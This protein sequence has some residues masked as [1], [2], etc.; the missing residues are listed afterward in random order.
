METKIDILVQM[1]ASV[2]GCV[3]IIYGMFALKDGKIK[4]IFAKLGE[5]TLEIYVI[6]YHFANMLNFNNKQYD[7]YTPEGFFFVLASFAAMSAVTFAFIW[8][9]KKIKIL[10]LL[11]FGR[12]S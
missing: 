6:H 7:F 10:N 9:M 4:N 3:P 5:F 1:I 11:F 2:F 12:K 8:V